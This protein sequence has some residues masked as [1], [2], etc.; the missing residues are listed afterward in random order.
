MRSF[1]TLALL[2]DLGAF[3]CQPERPSAAADP[4]VAPARAPSSEHAA[5]SPSASSGALASAP[6]ALAPQPEA[7]EAAL[8]RGAPNLSIKDA[9]TEGGGPLIQAL[10]DARDRG[11][12]CPSFEDF[13][14]AAANLRGPAVTNPCGEGIAHVRC[15][16]M[17]SGYFVPVSVKREECT[18][19]LWFVP[20]AHEEHVLVVS[21]D[22]EEFDIAYTT[23]MFLEDFEG[24]GGVE[25]IVV[26]GYSHPE[27]VADMTNAVRSLADGRTLE[28]QFERMTD[29]DGDGQR[30]AI[31]THHDQINDYC[32]LYDDP[33]ARLD[34][35]GP[36]LVLHKLKGGG[37][38]LDDEVARRQRDKDCKVKLEGTIIV[39]DRSGHVDENATATKALCQAASG[40]PV[41]PMLEEIKKACPDEHDHAKD[42]PKS[43]LSVC[44]LDQFLPRWLERVEQLR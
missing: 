39:R 23:D 3:G 8:E 4:R 17:A 26:R 40:R 2:A 24:K 29:V 36:S 27:G 28:T 33:W 20:K 35:G 15:L 43:R 30:D 34:R 21:N 22:Y 44:G 6:V 32:A 11:L 38:S 37:F 1:C 14:P 13:G 41:A 12:G 10:R 31:L 18:W 9:V 16:E 42:C 7:P 25:A 19:R 5:P